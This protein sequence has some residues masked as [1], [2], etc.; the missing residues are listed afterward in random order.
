MNFIGYIIPNFTDLYN[1]TISLFCLLDVQLAYK[2]HN[3]SVFSLASRQKQQNSSYS[4]REG[5]RTENRENFAKAG[6]LPALKQ[7]PK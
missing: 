1:V 2:Q 7:Q 6:M 3:L 4:S 5:G